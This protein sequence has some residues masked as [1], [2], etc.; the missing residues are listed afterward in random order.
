VHVCRTRSTWPVFMKACIGRQEQLQH[1]TGHASPLVA[2]ELITN[3][4]LT[5]WLIR[6][7]RRERLGYR[8]VFERAKQPAFFFEGSTKL[9]LSDLLY[10]QLNWSLIVSYLLRLSYLFR[11]CCYEKAR[12]VRIMFNFQHLRF[13]NCNGWDSLQFN[14][15]TSNFAV[16][17]L[18]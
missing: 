6:D 5:A 1:N 3:G 9:I 17:G 14:V 15:K 7:S 4:A 16:L 11:E 12:Y 2:A 10:F 13:I 8:D 18:W